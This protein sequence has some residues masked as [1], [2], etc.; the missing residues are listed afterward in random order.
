VPITVP[1]KPDLEEDIR[2]KLMFSSG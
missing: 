2:V 1:S